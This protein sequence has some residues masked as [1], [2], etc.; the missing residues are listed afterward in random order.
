MLNKLLRPSQGWNAVAWELAIV[1]LGVIIAL[2]A[3][4]IAEDVRDRDIAAQT[5]AEV[6]DELNAALMSIALRRSAEPCINRR[7]A[8]LRT[9]LSEW[10]QQGS[11]DTPNWVAQAPVVWIELSR[12]NAA[13]S[14][15]RMTLLSGEE[16]YRMGAVAA[17]LRKFDEWQFAERLPWGRL[18]TL[19]MGAA[20]LSAQDR[21]MIRAALQDAS[22][23]DYESRVLAAQTL[24]MA[25][26]F[27][28]APNEK[29]FREMAPQVWT[30]GK[31][32]PSICTSINTAPEEANKTQVTP[33]AM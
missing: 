32:S 17:R 1:A 6:T 28:F 7:L 10:E 19:Q 29:G 15:G 2:W 11:F 21:A 23:L 24:P 27:G 25:R 12:Y 31:F 8:E 33:L 18:R 16:Q 3:Q 26:R 30:G 5:R 4:Q 14:A 13:L 20:A 9:I 22:T